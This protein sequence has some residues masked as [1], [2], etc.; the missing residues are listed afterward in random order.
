MENKPQNVFDKLDK[1]G[2]KIEDISKKIEGIS[3]KDLYALAKRTWDYGD[4]E[5]AQKYYNHISL[6][7]PL[8][9]E[10]P[11]YAS[12]CNSYGGKHDFGY[13]M[14]KILGMRVIF[15]AT[16]DYILNMDIEESRKENELS[17]CLTIIKENMEHS[18]SFSLRY[19]T[20]FLK[21]NDGYFLDFQ[22]SLYDLFITYNDSSYQILNDFCVSVLDILVDIIN[23]TKQISK[24]ISKEVYDNHL[25]KVHT[26]MLY[27]YEELIGYQST[28]NLSKEEKINIQLNGT[29]YYEYDDKVISRRVFIKGL[30]ISITILLLSILGIILSFGF[31]YRYYAPFY[32]IP[33]LTGIY[34]FIKY[35]KERERINYHLFFALKEK[36]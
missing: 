15:K 29:L 10:A 4:Y 33:L 27:K 12:L 31:D 34:L 11:L 13:W 32:G 21:E 2:E 1:Q 25:I 26:Q 7:Q 16:I 6:L 9:W 17:R 8:D 19:K 28:N 14:D 5:T 23:L 24:K 18:K 20:E 3:V 36:K 22:N 30:I 35:V